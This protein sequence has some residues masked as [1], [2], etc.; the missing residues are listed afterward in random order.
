MKK[1]IIKIKELT[2]TV[3]KNQIKLYN[4]KKLVFS[5]RIKSF[6]IEKN[7]LIQRLC[8]IAELELFKNIKI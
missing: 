3:S 1:E 7:I 6:Q 8:L 2:G 4:N 5:G